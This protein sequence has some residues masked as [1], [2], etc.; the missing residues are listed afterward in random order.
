MKRKKRYDIQTNIKMGLEFKYV[1]N[2]GYTNASGLAYLK[3]CAGNYLLAAQGIEE[4]TRAFKQNEGWKTGMIFFQKVMWSKVYYLR[5][6]LERGMPTWLAYLLVD[7]VNNEGANQTDVMHRL[8]C[9]W[10]ALWYV[11]YTEAVNTGRNPEPVKKQNFARDMLQ[12]LDDEL[13]VYIELPSKDV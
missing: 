13:L 2:R 6:A 5:E 8:V 1:D 9:E 3:K 7:S 10:E 12:Q 11:F 4:G